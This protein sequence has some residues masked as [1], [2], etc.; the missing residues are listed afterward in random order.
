MA[1]TIARSRRTGH[2]PSS[3]RRSSNAPTMG[4]KFEL[5]CGTWSCAVSVRTISPHRRA[6]DGCTLTALRNSERASY[7]GLAAWSACT[8]LLTSGAQCLSTR[9]RINT[10]CTTA[11]RDEARHECKVVR[12]SVLLT[13]A[14]QDHPTHPEDNV[15][16]LI[17]GLPIPRLRS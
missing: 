9:H 2:M 7:S 13:C 11:R 17:S 16:V 15:D 4:L 3:V 10:V 5:A 12:R 14:V 8:S 6:T 1:A